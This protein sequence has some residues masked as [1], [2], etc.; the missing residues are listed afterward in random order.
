M[1]NLPGIEIKSQ[2]LTEDGSFSGYVSVFGNVDSHGDRV[3]PGAF[4]QDGQDV[5]L[6]WAHKPDEVI[7]VINLKGDGTGVLGA[8]KLLLDTVAGRE[9]YSRLK[10][11]AAKGLSVGIRILKHVRE[12]GV[13][14]IQSMNVAEVSL[15][16]FPANPG[17]LVSSV[18]AEQGEGRECPMKALQQLLAIPGIF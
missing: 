13:R 17:A 6:L 18:K 7:G 15:V 10:A 4:S 8:G 9:A 1:D 16:P 11:G 3:A 12:G 2:S 5:P 14:V